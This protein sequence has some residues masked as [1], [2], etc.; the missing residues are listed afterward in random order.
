MARVPELPRRDLDHVFEHTRH[1]W[2]EMR[3]AHV[4]ITGASGFVG[5][6]MLETLLDAN[7][8]LA[9]GV[10]VTALVRDADTFSARF[11]HLARQPDLW[12]VAGDVRTASLPAGAFTHFVHCASA[13]TPQVNADRP[14]E[15]VALIETGTRQMIEAAER[16]PGARFLQMSSGSIYGPQP[17]SLARVPESYEG[18]AQ[19]TVPAERFGAAKRAAERRGGEAVAHGVHFTSA[20]GFG[21]VGPR[22]PL[23]G[24]FALGNFIADAAANRPVAVHGDGTPVRSW[25]HAADL[26]AW[27]WTILAR[28]A[29]GAAYN[30]GSDHALTIRDA[31]HRV[32]ALATPPAA[33]VCGHEPVDGAPT[34]RFVPDVTRARTELG[35]DVWIPFDDALRR[36]WEWVRE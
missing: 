7:R 24:Q 1:V 30:V 12:L 15:V 8:S 19:A 2:P 33:V 22:L 17:A 5:S 23:D 3:G 27:C 11:P 35:L 16:S 36:T 32:A 4:L 21:L 20:R 18:E 29:A 9:L 26:A 10:E 6:W 25:L 13:A 34:S 28:G 14:D 31:A